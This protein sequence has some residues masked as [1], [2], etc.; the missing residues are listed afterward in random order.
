MSILYKR[1]LLMLIVLSLLL[2]VGCSNN[3]RNS[4]VNKKPVRIVSLTYG[5]DEILVALVEINRIIAFSK[6]A[7][8]SG[9]TYITK[10]EA[11]KVF[12][13]ADNNIENIISMHPD[14]IISS[15][16][17]NVAETNVLKEMGYNIC[18]VDSPKNIEEMRT[19]ILNVARA[20]GELEK[21]QKVVKNMDDRLEFINKKLE[22][23]TKDKEKV[24]LAFSYVGAIGKSG[25]LLD[26]MFKRAHLRNAVAEIG[27][28]EGTQRIS[29]EQIIKKNP[30][31][32]FLPTWDYSGKENTEKYNE[33]IS[34]DPA[35]ANIIAI[36]K[37]QI[38]AVNDRDRYVASQHVVDAIYNI[39]KTVYSD[40]FK[41]S[42]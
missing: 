1:I 13:R 19:K 36:K 12:K 17:S 34:N 35:Y 26:T 27:N 23:I 37:H 2:V 5:T 18:L 6:W 8:D 38:Y 20:V 4:N 21:G 24:V 33:S 14:L 10:E 15:K 40:K 22:N 28:I 42:N 30:D 31:V 3:K 32:F 41:K 9:I 25:N 7:D 16:V 39:A 29:K 11:T